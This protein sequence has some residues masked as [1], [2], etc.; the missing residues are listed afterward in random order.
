MIHVT[1]LLCYL[2]LTYVS[3]IAAY[4]APPAAE[5]VFDCDMFRLS[6]QNKINLE[7]NIEV[8]RGSHQVQ[9]SART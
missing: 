9:K 8:F 4:V 1:K 3:C 5:F 7:F 2:V 6:L